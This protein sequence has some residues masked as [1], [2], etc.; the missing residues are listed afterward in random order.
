MQ[1]YQAQSYA[2]AMELFYVSLILRNYF[3]LDLMAFQ[4]IFRT[5]VAICKYFNCTRK[6]L[7]VS[8]SFTF[9][10]DNFRFVLFIVIVLAGRLKKWCSASFKLLKA[11]SY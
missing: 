6:Q 5:E 1:V 11:L 8:N 2:V 10:A 7:S 3:H 4:L 9:F